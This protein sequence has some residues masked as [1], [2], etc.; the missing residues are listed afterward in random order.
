MSAGM[1]LLEVTFR[2]CDTSEEITY[3]V[4]AVSCR[5]APVGGLSYDNEL[6]SHI[7]IPG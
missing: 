5:T 6:K 1:N 3:F 7:S 2:E 4:T